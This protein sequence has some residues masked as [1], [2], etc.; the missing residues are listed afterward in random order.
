MLTGSVFYLILYKFWKRNVSNNYWRSWVM[1][2]C[3]YSQIICTFIY[4]CVSFWQNSIFAFN[5]EGSCKFDHIIQWRVAVVWKFWLVW[6]LSYYE[7]VWNKYFSLFLE[8][9]YPASRVSFDLPRLVG[10]LC[11]R[12]RIFQSWEVLNL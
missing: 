3:R 12:G 7:I 11:S 2:I 6:L 4:H 1:T 5:Y 10:R 9:S 8:S